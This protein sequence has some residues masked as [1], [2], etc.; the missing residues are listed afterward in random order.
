[1]RGRMVPVALDLYVQWTAHEFAT[2]RGWD[3]IAQGTDTVRLS[4]PE[5]G[6]AAVTRRTSEASR[7]VVA[8]VRRGYVRKPSRDRAEAGFRAQV[9]HLRWV[10]ERLLRAI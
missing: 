1:M 4:K 10:G 8:T 6:S 5:S 7:F 9:Q 3:P 2:C